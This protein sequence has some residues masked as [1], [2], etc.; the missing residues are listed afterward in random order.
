M[1]EKIMAGELEDRLRGLEKVMETNCSE[2]LLCSYG[3]IITYVSFPCLGGPMTECL[4]NGLSE[5]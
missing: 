2:L 5:T 3:R 4:N 1:V